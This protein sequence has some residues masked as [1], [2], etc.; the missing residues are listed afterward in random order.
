MESK[1]GHKFQTNSQKSI[2]LLNDLEN[3]VDKDGTII[4]LLLFQ[5]IHGLLLKKTG[6]LGFIASKEIS[7]RISLKNSQAGKYLCNSEP[8]MISKIIF[9]L[10]SEKVSGDSTKVLEKKIALLKWEKSSHQFF[11]KL[12]VTYTMEKIKVI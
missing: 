10:L 2:L 11:P 9:I 1:I 5:K 3:N 8:T 6:S 4:F 7:G 12:W